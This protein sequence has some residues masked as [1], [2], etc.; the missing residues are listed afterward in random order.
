LAAAT[1]VPVRRTHDAEAPTTSGG[2]GAGLGGAVFIRSGTLNISDSRFTNNR[3][4]GGQGGAPDR[5]VDDG[6][7]F[8]GAIFAVTDEAL[9]ANN[10]NNAGLPTETPTV[11]VNDTEF[12]GNTTQNPDSDAVVN[13]VFGTPAVSGSN[14]IVTNVSGSSSASGRAEAGAFSTFSAVTADSDQPE[15]ATVLARTVELTTRDQ[16]EQAVVVANTAVALPDDGIR[17]GAIDLDTVLG[18]P[19][20]NEAQSLAKTAFNLPSELNL[21]TFDPLGAA[22]AGDATGAQVVAQLVATQTVIVQTSAALQGVLPDA[23]ASA[24][25]TAAAGAL[26]A[27]IESQVA[28]GQ[29]VDLDNPAQLQTLLNQYR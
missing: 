7:G 3:A 14:P 25:E 5:T 23:S 17:Y 11:T 13:D 2:G 20:T 9:Q 29:T 28:N 12:S 27:F 8:G 18:I 22:S 6:S 15:Q 19:L 26:V 10:G 4:A 21:N 16:P 1:P 24:L